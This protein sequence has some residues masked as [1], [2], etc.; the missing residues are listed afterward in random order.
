MKLI[1][2][3]IKSWNIERAKSLKEKYKNEHEIMLITDKK[4]LKLELLDEFQPDYIFFPHWSYLIPADIYEKYTCVVFHMTDLPFGR[5]GSP[6]QNLIIRKINE[7]KVSAIKVEKEIDAGPIYMKEE[8]S[9]RGSAQEI[10]DRVSEIVFKKMIPRFWK[11]EIEPSEQQ[12]EVVFFKRRTPEQSELFMD[13]ETDDIYDYIRMLD[14]EEY[15]NAFLYFG[16]Y[17]LSF[18]N[19]EIINGK[20]NAKVIW[21]KKNKKI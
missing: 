20:L 7:T 4:K 16:E 1:I 17:K 13:M 9:L 5:G 6:L 21:E 18:Q 19:A 11:E 3:T 15:P 12:G 8:V 10:F 14:A 2:A